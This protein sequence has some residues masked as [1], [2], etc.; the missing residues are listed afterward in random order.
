MLRDALR[1]DLDD[2]EPGSTR[3]GIHLGAAGGALDILQRCYTGLDTRD[4]IL[5]FSPLLPDE[6][7]S[8]HFDIRYRDQWITVHIGHSRL[9]LRALPCA[10]SPITV[11]VRGVFHELAP[12]T[13]LDIPL[14]EVAP[15]G[16]EKVNER[17]AAAG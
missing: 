4:N 10:A 11:A 8:L 2:I 14:P 15:H 12:D 13:T 1:G 17:Q 6:L 16:R 5:W 3:E 7:P 9:L